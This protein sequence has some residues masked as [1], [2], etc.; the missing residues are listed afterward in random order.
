[1][2]KTF[3]V[4]AAYGAVASE[5][6][7]IPLTQ[8]LGFVFELLRMFSAND[9]RAKILVNLYLELAHQY[10]LDYMSLPFAARNVDCKAKANHPLLHKKQWNLWSGLVY[11]VKPPHRV[12]NI[13]TRESFEE[14]VRS[15]FKLW[16]LPTPR[17]HPALVKIHL[18]HNAFQIKA[19]SP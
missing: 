4:R 19:A 2:I 1:M 17:P 6:L 10:L 18:P 9:G 16:R 12:P 13:F 5:S 14:L 3:S 15:G 8:K 11:V 7:L